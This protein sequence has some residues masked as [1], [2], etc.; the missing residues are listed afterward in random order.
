MR[1]QI[2]SV[3]LI[4][5][6]AAA[7]AIPAHAAEPLALA[8]ADFDYTDT[9]GETADQ[10]QAHALRLAEFT[11]LVGAELEKSGT[12]RIVALS[13]AAPPCTPRGRRRT[14]SSMPRATPARGCC[15][16]AASTR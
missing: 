4:G 6:V 2:V 8:V 12:Y 5:C 10:K 7:L 15:S 11:R 3:S 13:C 9:S 16:M 1:K 14:N